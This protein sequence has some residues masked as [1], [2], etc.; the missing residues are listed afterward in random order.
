[1]KKLLTLLLPLLC[2]LM[3]TP[4]SAQLDVQ[5]TPVRHD[6]ITGEGAALNI[7]ITNHTDT[8]LQLN[9]TPGRPWLNVLVF[10]NGQEAP[11]AP[12]ANAKYPALTLS[13]GS[14]RAF[15]LNLKDSYRLDTTG[16]YKAVATIRMPNNTETYSS[17]R[18]GFAMVPGG[19]F[20]T[21]QVQARG[22]KLD[23]SV[24]LAQMDGYSNLFGQ[25]T[26]RE[27]HRAVGACFM[28][29]YLNFMKPIVKL[30]A[31]QNLHILCQSSPDIYTYAVMNTHGE[32]THYQL[33]KR[34]AGPIDLVGGG[35]GGMT[36]V[37][38]TPFV[39]AKGDKPQYNNASDR[40]F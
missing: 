11:I 4:A 22:R 6:F 35:K 1:M 36:P 18:A 2:L 8:T 38:L 13:P 30:D 37:G 31:A 12:I 7:T 29:R 17:N 20:R 25:V 27:T 26:D 14:R 5:L 28:A 3:L 16:N 39:P 10:R 9:N 40:P 34:T 33:Y 15:R 24:R 32:R 19:D 23:M 21:F